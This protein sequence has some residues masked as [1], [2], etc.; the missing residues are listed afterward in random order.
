MHYKF[1]LSF[2]EPYE[3][4]AALAAIMAYPNADEEKISRAHT[5]LCSQALRDKYSWDEEWANQPQR[6]KPVYAFH[7]LGAVQR[8]MNTINGQLQ[9]RLHAAHVAMAFFKEAALGHMPPDMPADAKRL[10][11]NELVRTLKFNGA[12]DL[13]NFETRIWRPSLPV[14]HLAAALA[15][16]MD[17]ASKEGK[18]T[19]IG[20][21]IFDKKIIT[22]VIATAQENEA[23]LEKSK[24]Q[25]DMNKIVRVRLVQ[26]PG[27]PIS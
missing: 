1:D 13:D 20:D 22:E 4:G 11:I 7:D 25:I 12:V 6:I 15:I 8:D 23:W 21:L 3:I 18:K 10:S 14:I 24:I 17:K 9:N 2:S 16:N 19:S 26:E 27:S 5:V